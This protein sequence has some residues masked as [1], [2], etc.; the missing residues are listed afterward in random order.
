MQYEQCLAT[1]EAESDAVIVLSGIKP[2]LVLE[3]DWIE[4][5][6]QAWKRLSGD[7]DDA[8]LKFDARDDADDE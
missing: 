5:V 3:D 4:E 1:C 7:E 8:F 2:S 6:R